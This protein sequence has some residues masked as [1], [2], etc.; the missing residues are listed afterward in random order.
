MEDKYLNEL[1][2]FR[3]RK[4]F[5]ETPENK[6]IWNGLGPVRFTALAG[7]VYPLIDALGDLGANQ[8]VGTSPGYAQQNSAE[9]LLEADAIIMSGA[10]SEYYKDAGMVADSQQ[11]DIPDTGWTR[12][13]EQT[14]LNQAK[15]LRDKLLP[16]SVGAPAPGE[17]YGITA[18]RVATYSALVDAFEE[19]I[20]KPGSKR[21]DRKGM[22]KTIPDRC[23]EIR[24]KYRSMVKLSKQFGG[25]PE[26]DLFVVGFLNSGSIDDLPGVKHHTPPAAPPVV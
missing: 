4:A 26:G 15:L 1:A 14:L 23:R 11:W 3:K 7:E 5:L 12:A 22:T 6:L 16:L 8:S 20:G 10:I 9:E 21:S 25:S 24:G 13:R 17:P 18:A 2:A 19:E